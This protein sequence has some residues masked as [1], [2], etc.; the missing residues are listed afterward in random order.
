MDLTDS[1][2][3]LVIK[4]WYLMQTMVADVPDAG[5]VAQ[6]AILHHSVIDS[7]MVFLAFPAVVAADADL[8]MAFASSFKSSF[9]SSPIENI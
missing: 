7:M 1:M 8:E 4:L 9:L 5:L 6:I 3:S 2:E